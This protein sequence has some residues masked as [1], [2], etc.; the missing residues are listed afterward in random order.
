MT[1]PWIGPAVKKRPKP[2]RG[3]EALSVE[4]FDA[5]MPRSLDHESMHERMRRRVDQ[6]YK[7]VKQEKKV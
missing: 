2:P 3:R 4:E 5:M 7:S 1:R 6:L